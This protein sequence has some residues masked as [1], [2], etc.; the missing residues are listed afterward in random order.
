[1][2]GVLQ[3]RVGWQNVGKIHPGDGVGARTMAGFPCPS[4]A[5]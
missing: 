2:C 5:L 1:V 3:P 4:H